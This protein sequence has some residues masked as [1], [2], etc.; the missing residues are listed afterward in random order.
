MS[1][2]IDLSVLGMEMWRWE[3]VINE[4]E[5]EER[6]EKGERGSIDECSL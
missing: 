4:V 2:V 1:L 3:E 6:E 5:K